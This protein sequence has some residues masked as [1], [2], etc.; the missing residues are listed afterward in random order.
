MLKS[1]PWLQNINRKI[2][3]HVD[4]TALRLDKSERIL[5]FDENLFNLFLSS[6][7]QYDF[8]V[9]PDER[10]LKK[11]I[12]AYCNVSSSQI[13][14]SFGSDG[15]IKSMFETFVTEQSVVIT[16]DPCFPMYD[17]YCKLF[18]ATIKK[19]QYNR[20]LKYNMTDIL[21]LI[22]SNT[23]L[24]ILANPNNPIGDVYDELEFLNVVKRA[25]EY[26]IPILVDEAY[27]EFSWYS[28]IPLISRYNNIFVSKTFSKAFGGAGVRLGYLVGQES[29]IEIVEKWK[30]MYCCTG[31]SIK[32]A[33]F[34]LDNKSIVDEY[35]KE[36]ILHRNLACELLSSHG[37][38]V[39]NSNTNWIHFNDSSDNV[40]TKKILEEFNVLY[41][42]GTKIP[43]DSRTDWI[44]LT[45]GPSV[46]KYDFFNKLLNKNSI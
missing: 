33:K 36:T 7:N 3:A 29:E 41:K 31:I 1:K 43:F 6:L 45:V 17:I 25:A 35:C 46:T 40:E 8:I 39:I 24:I 12:A 14:T 15:V 27:A 10:I 34:I 2:G 5:N 30:P 28:A 9:Y 42:C 26:N 21:N 38:D 37:Y 19:V 32:F 11:Y 20:Q 4:T 22:D 13:Y 23:S 16:T 44:R 18:N